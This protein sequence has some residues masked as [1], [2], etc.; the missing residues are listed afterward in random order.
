MYL[1]KLVYKVG[2]KNLII[3][4]YLLGAVLFAIASRFTQCLIG[5]EEKS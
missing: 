1:Y 2:F 5:Q 3:K 4:D